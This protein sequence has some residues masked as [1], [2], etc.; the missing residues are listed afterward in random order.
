MKKREIFKD[1]ATR[2]SYLTILA[3]II[4]SPLASATAQPRVGG[5][6]K[7]LITSEPGSVYM[8]AQ[9][10]PDGKLIAFTSDKFNGIWVA[11]A[12]G[13]NKRL[14]TADESAGFGFSWSPDGKHILGRSSITEGHRRMHQV[15]LFDVTASSYEI[16]VEKTNALSGLPGWSA[17]GSQVFFVRNNKVEFA[18]SARLQRKNNAA[19][20]APVVVAVM[21]KMYS[22]NPINKSLDQVSE[23]KGRFIFNTSPSPDGSKISFQVQGLGLYVMNVDG[24]GLR[25]IGRG[26]KAS[27]MPDGRYI[28]VSVTEDDGY[29]ITG[30]E[31][32]A[33]D[34]TS[35][36]SFLLTAHISMTA[37]KPAVSPDGKSVLFDN[38]D[39]GNI[40]ILSIE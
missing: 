1:T 9:W 7:V 13:R 31:L 26:E 5:Q 29:N 32:Y 22:V 2:L 25:N 11:S 17:D 27:W 10:S 3:V 30:G 4:F 18:S 6:P 39:D 40:Y 28:I 16:L 35:G 15:K 34:V 19:A 36:D 23:F 14:L 8:S 24:T 20:N 37:L 12:D 33:V 21:D 38:P